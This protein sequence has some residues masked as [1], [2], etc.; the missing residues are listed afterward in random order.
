MKRNQKNFLSVMLVFTMI[1][2][3]FMN[4]IQV[5]A[6]TNDTATLKIHYKSSDDG[7]YSFFCKRFRLRIYWGR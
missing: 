1:M 3:F 5:K 2:T 4:A 6:E 7:N